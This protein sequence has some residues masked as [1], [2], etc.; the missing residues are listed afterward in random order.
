MLHFL[1][2]L[3]FSFNLKCH[4]LYFIILNIIECIFLRLW[5]LINLLFKWN[6]FNIVLNDINCGCSSFSNWLLV[7]WMLNLILKKIEQS[8]CDRWQMFVFTFIIIL[9]FIVFVVLTQNLKLYFFL[10][11]TVRFLIVFSFEIVLSFWSIRYLI[12]WRLTF[13]LVEL[14]LLRR[15]LWFC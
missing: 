15:M 3:Q 11:F 12:Q 8:R 4:F 14:K 2:V 9:D 1:K 5:D 6:R 13:I 10:D 7:T